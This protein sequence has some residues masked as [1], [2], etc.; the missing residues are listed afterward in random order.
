MKSTPVA[1]RDRSA[2]PSARWSGA[3][4]VSN[5][6]TA[7]CLASLAPA[8]IFCV[9]LLYRYIAVEKA[10]TE[11]H[12]I[13][14]ARLL[15]TDVDQELTAA[16]VSLEALAKSP[17]ISAEDFAGFHRHALAL[18]SQRQGQH[19]V[20]MTPTGEQ[21]VN[22][23]VPWGES[24][25]PSNNSDARQ[26]V[27]ESGR[28]YVSDLIVGA[29]SQRPTITVTVPVV[30][31]DRV[32]HLLSYG[33]TVQ[34]LAEIVGSTR[35]PLNWQAVLSD[36]AGRMIAFSGRGN[37]LDAGATTF[38]P[39]QDESASYGSDEDGREILSGH[40]MSR[41]TGWRLSTAVR[42]DLSMLPPGSWR[43]YA[44]SGGV[45]L[46]LSLMLAMYL[47]ARVARPLRLTALAASAFGRGETMPQLPI[48]MREIDEVLKALRAA[49][50]D[51]SL[52][53]E[54]L[55]AAH[56]R[57]TLALSATEM[58]MWERDLTTDRVAWSDAM[59]QIFGRTY[60]SFSGDPDEVLGFVHPEDRFAFRQC[61]DAAVRGSSDTFEHECRIVRPNGEV[62]WI[63]RRAFIRRDRGGTATSVTGVALDVTERK[64]AEHAN[65]QLAAI[66]A[67]SSEAI[68]SVSREGTIT[69]WNASAERT[70]GYSA[71]EAIGTPL[72]RLF[73][74]DRGRDYER[75]EA[76]ME[77]GETIRLET[78]CR[79]R[80]G[81]KVDAY[82]V[83]SPV[84]AGY[85]SGLASGSVARSSVTIRDISERKDRE[86]H[87]ASVLRELTHRSKNLLAI[88]QAMA[89]QTAIGSETLI[90]FENRF[91]GRLQSLSRSHELLIGNDWEGGSLS[92][93]VRLQ[94]GTFGPRQLRID[95]AGPEV[96]LRPEAI[97]N[98]GLVLHELASN[99]ERHGA[100]SVPSGEVELRWSL[101]QKSANGAP[102]IL[103]WK[104]RGA[105]CRPV[106]LQRGFGRD[107]IE[108]V[109]P[110]ALGAKVMLTVHAGG[111]QWAIEV[112]SDQFVQDG[113]KSIAA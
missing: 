49:S 90:D 84:L 17:A 53:E 105:P 39:R 33:L 43:L 15:M 72:L 101:E 47:A 80:E 60:G 45:L 92:E 73:D 3:W 94:K 2:A 87:L 70:F 1:G 57:M 4:S 95:A 82:V 63:Y 34:R 79:R 31:D 71:D 58:G 41:L 67:S 97:V 19:I 99:A 65:A 81:Q 21:V 14:V 23:L 55:R 52:A 16:I 42:N 8:F 100:L 29:V 111:L 89:R 56:E 59:Y 69:T 26:K 36:R 46:A 85:V 6:L 74:E 112:P 7:F 25:P 103:V 35:L 44:A 98:L 10:Q 109:M 77:A 96:F 32:V 68:L 30:R 93:L 9:V 61:Y 27:L 51:R 106:P 83:L 37:H 54:R 11:Q 22:T 66:V 110:T 76:A 102:L 48:A 86:R 75:I 5:Y 108:H 104:E 18:A 62:R 50:A 38:D 64:L 40:A 24:L 88:V 91:S 20:L 107:I 78:I 13:E 28:P 12:A 113:R